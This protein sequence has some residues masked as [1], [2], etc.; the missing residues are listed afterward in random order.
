MKIK[1]P[2]IITLFLCLILAVSSSA[3]IDLRG[4]IKGKIVKG[5]LRGIRYAQVTILDLMS[6]ESQTRNTNDFGNFQFDNLPLGNIYYVTVK[7]KNTNG[8]V[9]YASFQLNVP[10][11][12]LR[13]VSN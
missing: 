6:L 11:S 7:T 4:I 2:A 12:E 5:N 10:V 1:I 13:I 9:P 3:Q 8:F